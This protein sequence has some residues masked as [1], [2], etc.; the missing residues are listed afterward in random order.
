MLVFP[1][2]LSTLLVDKINDFVTSRIS[3]LAILFKRGLP[4]RRSSKR[5]LEFCFPSSSPG[6]SER[7]PTHDYICTSKLNKR[8]TGKGS[9]DGEIYE[10][11]C[12]LSI[13]GC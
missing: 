3:L 12:T 2:A 10:N 4:K 11:K 13:F 6:I 5:A 8:R 9:P 7:W 1:Q